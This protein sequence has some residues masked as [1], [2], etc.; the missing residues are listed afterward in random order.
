MNVKAV[1]KDTERIYAGM[2]SLA[3]EEDVR[4]RGDVHALPEDYSVGAAGA[5]FTT[6]G[7]TKRHRDVDEGLD[8][9]EEGH[10]GEETALS[11]GSELLL[12]HLLRYM[13]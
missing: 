4:V 3:A 9:T 6:N 7:S 5:K 12:C 1:D 11:D 13:C 10:E 2:D 8:G